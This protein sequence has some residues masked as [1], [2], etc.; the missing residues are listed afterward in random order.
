LYNASYGQFLGRLK[1]E[2]V[3][4]YDCAPTLAERART[5]P[6]YLATDTHWR[7]EA[8][9]TVAAGLAGF[10]NGKGVLPPAR[11][12]AFARAAPV[13]VTNRGDITAMLKLP[14]AY[15]RFSGE[16]A[17][18]EPV[19][20]REANW[21]VDPAADVLLLGDSFSNIY[22]LPDLGWGTGA[23][24]AEQ[25]SFALQRPVDRIARNDSGAYATREILARE[26][27]RG[28]DR[29]AGKKVV[30]WQF[31]A[32]ELAHGDWKPV[33]LRLGKAA[34]TAGAVEE[35][36]LARGTLAAVSTRPQRGAVYRDFVIKFVVEGLSDEK[37][38]RPVGDG[39]AVVH[40][41]AMRNHM[42]LPVA[43]LREGSSLR[44]MIRPWDGVKA[45][46]EGLVDGVLPDPTVELRK[47]H[48]WGEPVEGGVGGAPVPVPEV[49]RTPAPAARGTGFLAACGAL[50]AEAV[51][52]ERGGVEGRD[53]WLFLARELR[54]LGAGPFWG[55]NAPAVSRA[56]DA[57]VSDPLP[58]IVDFDRQLKALGIELL[59]MPVPPKAVVY[60]DKVSGDVKP[61]A[62]GLPP[63]TDVHHQAF[64]RILAEQGVQVL[65]LTDDFILARRED[66]SEGP[67]YCMTDTHWAPRACAIA[68]KR[69][70]GQ[71]A[72]REWLRAAPK[73][74]YASVRAEKEIVGDLV[75]MSGSTNRPPERIRFARVGAG[76]D[77]DLVQPDGASPVVLL[78]DSHG[79]VFHADAD[80][81][82]VGAGLPDRLACEFGMPVD[83]VA[84][85]GSAATSVRLDLA[86]R[87][88]MDEKSR[89]AK[90]LII[91]CLA[92][93]DFTE[94]GGWHKIPLS[95]KK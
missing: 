1:G 13:T 85:R 38:G 24:L 19:L 5:G 90:K 48:Y 21:A 18:L 14:A 53:G 47:P 10:L 82:G 44:V 32:R 9:Q 7:P 4:V 22:S 27:A 51:A 29:L 71:V 12:D 37:T 2:G 30:I 15:P 26:L 16:T 64:Y 91:W 80:L 57:A 72:D 52:A 69:I 75:E 94:S 50:A 8:V 83:L 88:I 58:A 86:R 78:A 41:L 73:E 68:A 67:V 42:I 40:A 84:R 93:R 36:L 6:Q 61:D 11:N 87:F 46:Y 63:R 34:R 81:H 35:E 43:N 49:S 3:M 33:E 65:D 60:P 62:R 28:V 55:T 77:M 31:A 70:Q 89:K 66:A 79:L 92:A 45:R 59:L 54:H 23:G 39:T 20:R 56:T 17:V 95:L 76:P 25:L 74:A